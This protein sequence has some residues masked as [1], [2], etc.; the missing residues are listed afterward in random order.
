MSFDIAFDYVRT[1]SLLLQEGHPQKPA[2]KT[3]FVRFWQIHISTA[4]PLPKD[5][6][7]E[8]ALY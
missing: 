7:A 8:L 3:P 1:L 5:S 6:H 4:L 2:L